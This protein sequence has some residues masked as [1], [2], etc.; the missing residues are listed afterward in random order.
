MY[1]VHTKKRKIHPKSNTSI[2]KMS[3]RE[4]TIDHIIVQ[5]NDT[6]Q[7]SEDCCSSLFCDQP[8][9][10]NTLFYIFICLILIVVFFLILSAYFNHLS[11]G[12]PGPLE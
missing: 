11:E 6:F 2:R 7:A 1:I 9:S 3:T 8:P 12:F 4:N 5:I 10:S